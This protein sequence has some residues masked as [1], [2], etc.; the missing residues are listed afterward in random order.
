MGARG[1][2]FPAG[3]P[4]TEVEEDEDAPDDVGD[5]ERGEPAA[6]SPRRGGGKEEEEEEEEEEETLLPDIDVSERLRVR[7][8]GVSAFVADMFAKP[9]KRFGT[10]RR[11]DYK[12][13]LDSINGEALPGTITALMGPSGSGKTTLL[14]VL[15]GRGQGL[16]LQDGAV[17]FLGA[18]PGEPMRAGS[19]AVKRRLGF[20]TQDEVLFDALTVYETLRFT[21]LLKLPRSVPADEKG[22][23]ALAVLSKLGLSK[24]RDSI[25]GGPMRR[26]VSGGERKRVSI[27][28]E[29]LTNPS[30]LFLD[31]PTSGLDSTTALQLVHTLRELASGGRTVITSI[32][33]PS[34]RVFRVMDDV[35]LLANGSCIYYGGTESTL[36]YFASLGHAIPE[37]VNT[38]DF[39]L[40]VANGT[41]DVDVELLVE[42]FQKSGSMRIGA[43]RTGACVREPEHLEHVEAGSD[44]SESNEDGGERFREAM[45]LDDRGDADDGGPVKRA[46]RALFGLSRARSYAGGAGAGRW[47]VSW[48]AQFC[49]LTVRSFR[50]RRFEVL[51]VI[52]LVQ[53]LATALLTGALWFQVRARARASVGS[54]PRIECA[55]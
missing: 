29:L 38:A 11:E 13:I 41:E 12:Q 36:K 7:W 28:I 51:E 9:R 24:V 10:M 5:V 49:V 45:E 6:P 8:R 22:A 33:Q 16:A 50:Q 23:R 2:S 1:A 46:S 26:G 48:W 52:T 4:E 25:V 47:P 31:E 55:I 21:A 19:K 32:H 40:D 27:A 3:G 18:E 34:S 43:G 37:G 42:K 54:S 30:V 14:S 44:T 20:V 53:F 15:G 35:I 17:E 39:L